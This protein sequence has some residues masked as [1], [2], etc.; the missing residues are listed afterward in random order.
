MPRP[1][2]PKP[3]AFQ[4]LI[5]ILLLHDPRCHPSSPGPFFSPSLYFP[6]CCNCVPLF[7]PSLPLRRRHPDSSRAASRSSAFRIRLLAAPTLR[8]TG[9]IW[10]L[11]AVH[12]VIGVSRQ[13]QSG[14][15]LELPFSARSGLCAHFS[16]HPPAASRH[17][18]SLNHGTISSTCRFRCS[19]HICRC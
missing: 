17:N 5:L 12:R 1:P 6:F 16:A 3:F 13:E 15:A 11:L 18:T 7:I 9:N 2:W 8:A 14:L 10:L 19:P 4:N